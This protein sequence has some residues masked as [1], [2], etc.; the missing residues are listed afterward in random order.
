ME[1]TV[2]GGGCP[3][4]LKAHIHYM[5]G[6]DR[7]SKLL[8]VAVAVLIVLAGIEAYIIQTESSR[9]EVQPVRVACVGDSLTRGTEYTL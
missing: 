9:V 1:T 5:D 3:L 8:S 4:T 2:L 6:M 7:L